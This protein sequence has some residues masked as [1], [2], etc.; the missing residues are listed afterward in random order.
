MKNKV[1]LYILLPAA[2]VTLEMRV[3]RQMQMAEM[4]SLLTE[5]LKNEELDYLADEDALVMEAEGGRIYDR[6]AFVGEAGLSDGSRI[7]LI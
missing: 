7:I 3:P 4:I 1:L 6:N 5:W 2:G